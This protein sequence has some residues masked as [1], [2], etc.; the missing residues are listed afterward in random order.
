MLCVSGDSVKN[1]TITYIIFC[2]DDGCCVYLET[3]WRI[4]LLRTLF[5]AKMMDVVCIW[6][7]RE[8]YDYYVHYFLRRWWM[9]CV[10][11]DSV[12]NTTI[13]YIIF[14]EDDGCCVYLETA[15]RIRLLRTLF[16][17]KMMDVVCIWRQREEY[18]Y[19]VQYFLRRWWMY[20]CIWQREEYDYDVHYF[21]RRWWM[22]CV[23]GDS[24][25]NTTIT[26]I[27]FC[28][29]DGC[30]V[31]VV[32]IIWR[33]WMLC[34]SSVKN[35]TITYIVFC[36]DD[37]CCVYLETAW[38]IRLLRTLFSAKMIDVVCITTITYIVFCEDDW[39]CVYLET[40]RR[41]RLLR[42]LFSAKMMDVVCIW[43]QREE[44]D[45]Y[46]HYFLRRWWML[47]VSGDSVKNTTITYIIFCEDDWCCVYLETAWRI[48]LL[49]TLFSAK[50]MDVVCIWRQREEYDY[51]VH[52]L[53]RRWWMLCVS[54]DSVKNT[55]ITYII[56]CEDDC[57][58][59]VSGDWCCVYQREEYDY[60]VHYFLRR[61]W[62]LCVSGDSV[63]NT[64]I[65]YIIFCEDDWCC[66]YLETAW[67]IRLLRTLF[68]AKMMDVVCI[69]R[70]REEYD[71]YVHYFLR[72]WMDV[73][74]IWKRQREEYDYYVHYFLRR[75]WLLCVSGDS[76]KNTTMTYIIFCEDD[77]CCVYLETA[78]RIRLLRTLFSAKMMDVVYIWRQREEYD[79]YVHYFLR[80]WWMLCV[81]GDSAKNTT[82]TYII[83]CEDDGCY[84]YLET[85]WRIR[86]LRTL[87][88]A[89]MM[90]VVCIWRQREE[91]DYYV[92][93]FLRRWWMLCVSGDS[94]KNTTIT[95]IIF[96]EDDGCC[97]YLETAWRIRLLH[98]LFSAKMMDVVCI[99]RQREDDTTITYII[100]CEDDGCCVYL[101][102]AWRI[103]L[104]R[105]LFSAK[106]F[107][108]DDG[109]C[110]YLETAWRIRL[111]RT[112]FSAKMI[113]VVC[114]W[115]QREEYDYYDII[116]CEDDDVVYIW[117]TAWRI[118][119]LCT[120]FS[121]KMMD[122]VCIWRQREEYDYYVKNTTITYIIFCEDDG[123]C[124]YLETD[125][126]EYDYY[127]HYFLRRWWMLC[128]SGDSV[129]NTTITY[130][131][132]CEDDWCCVYLETAWKIRLLRT[133]FSAKMMDVV[134][135]WRQREE[136]DY[137]VHCF[138]RRW[139]MLCVSGDSV[140]NTTITY[141][142]FCEDDGCC[143][144]LETAWRIRL[145][146]TLFS[147]KMMDVV[148]IWRQREEYWRQREEYY[149]HYFLRRWWML[150]VS[151]D[152][153]KN[154]TITYIIFC[155]DDGCCVYLETAWRIRLLRTLFS[156]KMM[157]V[158][159]MYLETAAWRIRLLRTLFSAK[160]MDVVCIWRKREEYDYYVHYF[161]RRWWMLCVSG[162]SVKNTT[163][164]YIIFCED[165]DVVCIW[166]KREEYDY[167]V[168]YFLRRWW[169]LCVSGDSVKNTTITYIIFCEGDG[170]CVYLE[171]AWRIRLLRILFSAK[172]IDVVCI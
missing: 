90:D 58:L 57:V 15:W 164:T 7:Q 152:S 116:F 82:I 25:K 147:T 102:T 172:M 66:V 113:D 158:V 61:W 9:L 5:S 140:K 99:W 91:Y 31:Y 148:C 47:C 105:T 137:Y 143:V 141:I 92:H 162:D 3:A 19:Y 85:A 98:T 125:S 159:C 37:G 27:I 34:V 87:F 63:K 35:T 138:L 56:F 79:Y 36:E 2:E 8:E 163:I 73:V 1:T 68:S 118:R 154:T 133:L 42:T 145:L 157:D 53:L 24:V 54:G 150:C 110:V 78:W 13:T 45:Y 72:R 33:W 169:M 109:C 112:L 74:C 123:C 10:S 149:V 83:F 49:R 52:Y 43:R 128:V 94:V 64:T 170:C 14:C 119:L 26:Y 17:A 166:R 21:L 165:D 59:C 156:A 84:V 130:I 30:C 76:V 67:R 106:I 115:K 71:Y 136:Y 139:W 46:V 117:I 161:L 23:S 120:L 131:I 111:L 121:A 11:G 153:V 104:L 65:T 114:I 151:G 167:Y 55:T 160:M 171:T 50:M 48:R 155:K 60:Y 51:Y 127:V 100:F 93:C 6:R 4:R 96:C 108:E 16:S 12:K 129:K 101:E 103:R 132:F 81:S 32:Y 135:I 126:E 168:H 18:D 77:G 146:R 28:E 22:L 142:I 75:W 134:C 107:C 124:V 29:D 69:W 38:R 62:M 70:Q 20:V 89:K 44:Y 88:S 86:L 80:R 144:Y 39:C 95:Y 41:I 122:V 97:V 40:A